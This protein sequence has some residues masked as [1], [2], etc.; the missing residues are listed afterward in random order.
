MFAGLSANCL[1]RCLRVFGCP[2]VGVFV[3][4]TRGVG[5]WGLTWGFACFAWLR[6]SAFA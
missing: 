1:Q 5:V 4:V 6:V 3:L 2:E